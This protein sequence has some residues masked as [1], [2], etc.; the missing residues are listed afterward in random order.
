VEKSQVKFFLKP[1]NVYSS[2]DI[3]PAAVRAI[4]LVYDN[5]NWIP[6]TSNTG[7]IFCESRDAAF[8]ETSFGFLE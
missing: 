3:L 1:Q 8:S 4:P 5:V 2:D 6:S 7:K